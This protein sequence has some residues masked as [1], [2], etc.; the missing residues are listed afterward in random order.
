MLH[1]TGKSEGNEARIGWVS[2]ARDRMSESTYCGRSRP[3]PWT[4]Q[5]GGEAG[6]TGVVR[7]G[8]ESA[9][10]ADRSTAMHLLAAEEALAGLWGE[11][12]VGVDTIAANPLAWSSD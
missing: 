4:P 10:S 3:R 5:L 7:E 6:P 8:A 12:A 2:F 9:R 11:L 1:V